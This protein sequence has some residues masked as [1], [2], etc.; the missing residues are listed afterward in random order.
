[1][2]PPWQTDSGMEKSVQLARDLVM[3]AGNAESIL[4]MQRTQNA[5]DDE[6]AHDIDMRMRFTLDAF[7]QLARYLA[8]IPG[9]KNLVWL[10]GSFPM[11]IFPNPDVNG[12][13]PVTRNYENDI[14]KVTN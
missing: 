9:R 11:S 1:Q 14:K 6:K 12:Y 8:G 10:S 7:M 4:A 2:A 13:E 5:L 3:V